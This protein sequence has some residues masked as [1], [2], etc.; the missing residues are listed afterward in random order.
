MNTSVKIG[1]F[2]GT[3]NPIHNAHLKVSETALEQF[4]LEKIIFIPSKIPPHKRDRDLPEPEL[5][6]EMVEL[7]IKEEPRF[8]ISSIE[9]NRE[10]PSYTIDTINQMKEKY[11]DLAFIVGADNLLQIQTWKKPEK[12]LSSCP[13]LIAPRRGY[14][15]EDFKK[16]FFKDK[17]LI[18][19]EM[20]E[21]K[22]S[23]TKIRKM[24]QKGLNI[25]NFVPCSVK[26]FIEE[27]DIYKPTTMRT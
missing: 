1:L 27:R 12:L 7:A 5:R 20:E 13:F 23:S 3:F 11:D 15:E 6:Y 24:Y 8:E 14:S 9:I 10:G 4:G 16:G 21:I 26:R 22:I 18:F 2:G 17:D 19:L 25:D